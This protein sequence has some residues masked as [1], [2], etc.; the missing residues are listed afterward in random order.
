MAEREV[1]ASELSWTEP[2]LLRDQGAGWQVRLPP[3]RVRIFVTGLPFDLPG[4]VEVRRLPAN[5]PFMLAASE[6]ANPAIESWKD[7]G[8]VEL[9]PLNILS[10]L[11]EG[12]TLYKSSGARSDAAVRDALP[13]L[14]LP[15][16]VRVTLR[17]GIRSGQGASFF[18]FAPPVVVVDGGEGTEEVLCEGTRLI[19]IE[20][21][22]FFPLPDDLPAGARIT[23]EV[24]AGVDVVRRQS[25]FLSDEFE[26]R[27]SDRLAS[28]DRFGLAEAAGPGTNG[29]EP[30]VSGASGVHGVEFEPL[31]VRPAFPNDRRVFAIGR[32]TGQIRR[33]PAEP[34]PVEWDPIWL[35][36]LERKGRASY[37]G[38]DLGSASPIDAPAGTADE[39]ALWKDVLWRRR[40]RIAPP[41]H[42]ALRK[43]WA[44]YIEAGS[45]V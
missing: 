3:A 23:V 35:V 39:I 27:L 33:L 14:A 4:Y 31:P 41:Q 11:P 42:H 28:L 36:E 45:R 13:E 15:A 2:L 16:A 12:W 9:Q 34:F 29:L 8:G 32:K 7:S 24:R 25:L 43:L 19:P 30:R 17:G 6:G 38:R 44:A 10:G 37:C 18:K 1:D 40:K 5:K 21:T 26:W 20:Q 22:G